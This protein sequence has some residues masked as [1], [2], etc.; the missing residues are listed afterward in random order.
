MLIISVITALVGFIVVCHFSEKSG[1]SKVAT[2]VSSSPAA[3]VASANDNP[4]SSDAAS[5]PTASTP[6][7]ASPAP[8]GQTV[9]ERIFARRAAAQQLNNP[10]KE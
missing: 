6:T 3:P 10:A 5:T 7:S 2:T 1:G 4:P 8:S 9:R